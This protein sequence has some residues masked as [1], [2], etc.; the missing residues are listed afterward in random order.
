MGMALVGAAQAQLNLGAGLFSPR[1]SKVRA[2]FGDSSVAFGFGFGPA[3]RVGRKGFSADI[4]GLGLQAPLNRFTMIGGT[5]GYEFQQSLSENTLG[6]ARAGTGLAYYDYSLAPQGSV[7]ASGNRFA[8]LTTAEVGVVFNRSTTLS[9]Q[10]LWMPSVAGYDFS[11][12]RLQI[13]FSFR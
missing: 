1:D 6:F 9:A 2:I 13:A 10:Y 4:A 12:I 8:G 5:V 7:I 3:D 11:G